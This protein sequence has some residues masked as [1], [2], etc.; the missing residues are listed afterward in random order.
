MIS[1]PCASIPI[2]KLA[3]GRLPDTGVDLSSQPTLS[4]LENASRLCDVPP[5]LGPGGCLDGLLPAGSP[6]HRICALY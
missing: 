1:M 5:H 6:A 4:R 3:C 2:F